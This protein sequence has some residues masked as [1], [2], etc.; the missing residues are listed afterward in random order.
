MILK[1]IGPIV[2]AGLVVLSFWS[3]FELFALALALYP[4][5][6][7][8]VAV[9]W[10]AVSMTAFGCL[11]IVGGYLALKPKPVNRKGV[12]ISDIPESFP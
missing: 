4:E 7:T 3:V 11:I 9:G 8:W 10:A 5:N 1:I 2:T 12:Q 6:I